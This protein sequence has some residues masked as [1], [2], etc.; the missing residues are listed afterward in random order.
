MSIGTRAVTVLAQASG[1]EET[2]TVGIWDNRL[3]DEWRAPFGDWIEQAVF[4]IANNLKLLLDIVAWPF[5]TLIRLLVRDFLSEVSW[6]W[7]IMAMFAIAWLAR[8]IK[9][10]S[11]VAVAL[12]VCGVLGSQYWL[13][14]V[15]T[16]GFILVAVVICVVI[17]IPVGIV[18]GRVDSFW[19]VVRP[20]LDAM[21]VVHAFVYM[22]PIIWFFG[23]GETSATMVTMV[24]AIPPLIRLTNLGIRQVPGDV[25]EASR[26]YGAPRDE[27]SVRCSDPVGPSRHHDRVSIRHCCWP[28]PCWASRQSWAPAV[29][30]SSC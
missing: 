30:A 4:W 24:F 5:D 14:T 1:T 18:C 8:N 26:A 29:W 13:E 3:L 7:V 9:V 11:F 28:S 16:L 17:G 12:F 27:G 25:V 19:Q 10:A 2:E 15:R 20:I 6:L 22:L 21:Q 23:V